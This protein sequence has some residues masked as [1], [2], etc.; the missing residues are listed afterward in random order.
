[1][2]ARIITL[3]GLRAHLTRWFPEREFFMRSQGHVRFLRVSTRLQASLAGTIVAMALLWIGVLG[4]ALTAQ[5]FAG[6][7]RRA[8]AQREAAVS[9]AQGRVTRYHAD[10][11][12][13]AA[14]LRHRQDVLEKAV[15]SAIG[16]LPDAAASTA[17]T[18]KI[19]MAAPEAA[20]LT[21]IAARQAA[22]AD[23][24]AHFADDRANA[25]SGA[26]RKVGLNP[27]ELA[28]G[29][30]LFHL[31]DNGLDPRFQHLVASVGRMDAMD[32]GLS[33][34]PNTMPASFEYISS[35]FG[36]RSDPI[37]GGAAFHPGLDFKGP[38]GAPIYAAA[39]GTVSFAG[40]RS[41]YG[42]CVE[43]SHGHGLITRYAHMS[44][45]LA[46]QGEPV[47]PGTQIGLIGSTGRSTGPHLHFEVRINDRPVNPRP[48]LEATLPHVFQETRAETRGTAGH[49]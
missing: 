44:R 43:I 24:L 25:A 20:G 14:D 5:L 9:T 22:F 45:I 7:D 42:N 18:G 1:L 3:A 17:P 41:G 21:Q 31:A 13:L 32:A 36:R 34:V 48:F 47:T 19:S 46:R 11:D 33:H 35:G 4:W 26:I 49:G 30:P 15:R 39:A 38:L 12:A 40:Q 23:R 37:E 2:P 29:A 6:S 8:L 16:P 10:L 28:Q 27:A